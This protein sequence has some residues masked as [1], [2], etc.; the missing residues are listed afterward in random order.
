MLERVDLRSVNF[1]QARKDFETWIRDV[2]GDAE[3]ALRLNR[4]DKCLQGDV[5]RV[6]ILRQLKLRLKEFKVAL[7]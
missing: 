6:E 4:F 2:A 5:L 3:L 1:H 7:P